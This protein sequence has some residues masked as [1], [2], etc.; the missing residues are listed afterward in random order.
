ME[1]FRS[2]GICRNGGVSRMRGLPG[3]FR[4]IQPSP[5][6]Q[7][8]FIAQMDVLIKQA[9]ELPSADSQ[10]MPSNHQWNAWNAP[11]PRPESEPV[12]S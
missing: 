12:V 10:S 8:A 9:T 3:I 2:S 4:G 6:R 1:R 7:Y 5:F 11:Q